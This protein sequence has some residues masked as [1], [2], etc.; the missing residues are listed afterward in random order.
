MQAPPQAPSEQANDEAA[1]RLLHASGSGQNVS[2][3]ASGAPSNVVVVPSERWKKFKAGGQ[4][5]FTLRESKAEALGDSGMTIG[6]NIV[7][8]FASIMA[9]I[10]F[11][12]IRCKNKCFSAVLYLLNTSILSAMSIFQII[13]FFYDGLKYSD[14]HAGRLIAFFVYLAMA[15]WMMYQWSNEEQKK[16]P[17]NRIP[18]KTVNWTMLLFTVPLLIYQIRSPTLINLFKKNDGA[19]IQSQSGLEED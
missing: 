15:A 19:E 16:K 9:S 18:L 11:E 14:W 17:S 10:I 6:I 4:K 12:S 7:L 13:I 1:A 3:S 8:T 5:F 2:G